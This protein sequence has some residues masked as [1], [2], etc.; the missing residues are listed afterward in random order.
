MPSPCEAGKYGKIKSLLS[1]RL[2]RLSIKSDRVLFIGQNQ[3]VNKH[4]TLTTEPYPLKIA[5]LTAPVLP[6]FLDGCN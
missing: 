3:I 2:S 4:F 5:L 6:L 1:S